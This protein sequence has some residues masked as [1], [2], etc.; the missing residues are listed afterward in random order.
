MGALFFIDI[1]MEDPGILFLCTVWS[2]PKAQHPCL[3]IWVSMLACN[4]LQTVFCGFWYS[5]TLLAGCTLVWQRRHLAVL[6]FLRC[7]TCIVFCFSIFTLISRLQSAYCPLSQVYWRQ[8]GK[9]CQYVVIHTHWPRGFLFVSWC[10]HT[11]ALAWKQQLMSC[12]SNQCV[13]E[14]RKL[15]YFHSFFFFITP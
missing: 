5:C 1:L 14:E 11:S 8:R 4:P 9:V 13:K 7:E 10:T 6:S 12:E 15:W 2:L 3:H